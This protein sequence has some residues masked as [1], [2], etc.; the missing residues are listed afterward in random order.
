MRGDNCD[1]MKA[2]RIVSREPVPSLERKI[3]A[4]SEQ[5]NIEE[6]FTGKGRKNVNNSVFGSGQIVNYVY[7]WRF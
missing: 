4:L 7:L 2:C 5:S 6:P 1:E 3:G